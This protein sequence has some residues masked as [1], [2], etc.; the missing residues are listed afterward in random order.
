MGNTGKN[1]TKLT[2]VETDRVH[3][4]SLARRGGSS[5][6][7]MR[8]LIDYI[9]NLGAL[10][11]V[12]MGVLDSS[13]LFIPTGNDLLL[14]ALTARHH[15]NVVSYVLASSLGSMLGVLVIDLVSRKGGEGGLKKIMSRRTLKF[16]KKRVENRAGTMLVLGALA[17]PPFPFTAVVATA[18]AFQYPRV[19]LLAIVAG[20]RLFRFAIEGW[21]AIRFGH[22]I[23]T[24]MGSTEFRWAVGIFAVICVVGSIFSVGKWT[25]R[26]SAA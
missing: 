6:A 1:E 10:G 7:N 23:V 15:E 14:I 4:V 25:R 11:L 2:K 17:P 16:V 8:Q 21:V 22:P 18:S 19:E 13:F 26:G 5:H 3:G 24:M 9:F 12:L 20:A